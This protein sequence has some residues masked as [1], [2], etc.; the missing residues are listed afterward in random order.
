MVTT[1]A[2]T[3][4]T[5]G[6][7]LNNL[8]LTEINAA[9][10]AQNAN[11]TSLSAGALTGADG[12]TAHAGGGQGSATALTA[13]INRVTTVATAA[14]SV[15][16]PA[17][18]AG[19]FVAIV[20]DAANA[21]QAFGA[22]TDTINDVA[23]ATGVPVAGKTMAVFFCPVAG[24]WYSTSQWNAAFVNMSVATATAAQAVNY[25]GT[26]GGAN[27]ALTCNLVDISGGNIALAAGLRI[28]L[29]IAHTLQAGANTLALN[30]GATKAIK[31]HLNVANNIATG[32]AVA[33][34]IELVY[35]GTQ[36]QDLSQ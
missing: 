23:T 8:T 26:E 1:L 7:S 34:I 10:T 6:G 32:Y 21:L 18:T 17:A 35:D 9:I 33:S 12:I 3:T 11:N 30:G 19:L 25:Q 28:T 13:G 31:S 22:G 15:A 4:Q 29:K 5:S 24:K 14:D 20:N 36:W 2:K 16:L 27:N